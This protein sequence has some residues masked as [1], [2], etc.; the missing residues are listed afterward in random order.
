MPFSLFNYILFYA[1]LI[2]NFRKQRL[3]G[4]REKYT[5]MSDAMLATNLGG[6]ST[7]SIDPNSGLASALPG[8]ATGMLTPTGD[9]DVIKIG[10]ARQSLMELRVKQVSDSVSGQTNVDPNGRYLNMYCLAIYN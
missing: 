7:S 1:C 6:E 5:P 4:L 8:T 10:K 9:L 3:A 2:S